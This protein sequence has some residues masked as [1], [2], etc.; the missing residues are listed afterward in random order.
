[1]RY[2]KTINDNYLSMV[3]IGNGGEEI[4]ESEYT[5]LMNLISNRPTAPKGFGCRLTTGLV[6][7][8]YE[9][10]VAEPDPELSEETE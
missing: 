10:P 6:W 4:T 8:L 3:G 9:L 7:E 2:Y 1:M 5:E